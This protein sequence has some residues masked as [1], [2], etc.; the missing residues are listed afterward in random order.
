MCARVLVPHG[1][2][3]ADAVA[4]ILR[5]THR[6]TGLILHFKILK[7]EVRPILRTEMQLL[8]ILHL[9]SPF[10]SRLEKERTRILSEVVV[11]LYQLIHQIGQQVRRETSFI[12]YELFKG[13]ANSCGRH[14][15]SPLPHKI[16]IHR[17]IRPGEGKSARIHTPLPRETSRSIKVHVHAPY[18]AES[19]R[20]RDRFNPI[21][22]LFKFCIQF[23]VEGPGL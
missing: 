12:I 20:I 3:T 11:E 8:F 19:E 18:W 16:Q 14:C 5:G 17:R 6:S 21:L 9:I 10:L 13:R 1:D 7:N 23:S 2:Y 4:E 15:G 22:C